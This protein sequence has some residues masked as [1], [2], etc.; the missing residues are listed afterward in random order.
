[1]NRTYRKQQIL[2]LIWASM[3]VL[4]WIHHVSWRDE[5]L[6][7]L[8]ATRSESLAEFFTAIQYDRHPPFYYMI[9]R[10]VYK[11]LSLLPPFSLLIDTPYFYIQRIITGTFALGTTFL[12]LFRFSRVP[13]WF[14]G[15]VPF[16]LLFF[17]EYSVLS[18][19][20]IVGIFFFLLYLLAKSSKRIELSWIWLFFS[21][22]IHL[23]FTS[24]AGCFFVCD[25]FNHRHQLKERRLPFAVA[26][27]CVGILGLLIFQIPPRDTVFQS[28]PGELGWSLHRALVIIAQ[29][30]TGLDWF[31]GAF[32]WNMTIFNEKTA[33]LGILPLI[34]MMIRKRFPTFKFLFVIALPYGLLVS[35]GYV[36]F[37]YQG[38]IFVATVFLLLEWGM[39]GRKLPKLFGIYLFLMIFGT[40]RWFLTWSPYLFPPRYDFS[41]AGEIASKMG[42]E[43][44][45][46]NSVVI[47]ED[48][49]IFF[50][51]MGRMNLEK[52]FVP[53]YDRFIK[54]QFHR[55]VDSTGH[56]KHW[57]EWPE[58]TLKEVFEDKTIYV[59]L[60][61]HQ[62]PPP[63][64][65]QFELV[66]EHERPILGYE[67]EKHKI[68]KRIG[69]KI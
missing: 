40:L 26:A 48:P 50:P 39:A 20:Y 47:V 46:E 67:D 6:T 5:M 21:A 68:F 57:C 30:M 4:S 51:A 32:R 12:L 3:Y 11:T 56:R 49:E 31:W 9:L 28:T 23:F 66:F 27:F 69:P 60:M 52:V 44:T 34:Y 16:T 45:A 24:F 33:I 14:R 36:P 17:M 55:K 13:L 59:V 35:M 54:Y 62:V 42:K 19:S 65:G 53:A 43:L 41:G 10:G 7:W 22:G 58:E 64:C 63:N 1:M 18:R 15:S 8:I 61:P 38:I 37:R 2:F 25:L 29:G